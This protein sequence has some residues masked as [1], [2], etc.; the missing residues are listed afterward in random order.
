MNNNKQ[1]AGFASNWPGRHSIPDSRQ[2]SRG[3]ESMYNKILVPLDGSKLAEVV[4]PHLDNFTQG[5][6]S[7]EILLVSVTEKVRM[8]VPKGAFDKNPDPGYATEFVEISGGQ[9]G[10]LI[11]T[12]RFESSEIPLTMGKMAKSAFEYLCQIATKLE[13]QGYK[14]SVNV[15]TGNPAEQI[16]HFAEQEKADV[17]MMGSRG[18]SGFS[19]WDLGNIAEKVLRATQA[20]VVLVKPSVDFKETRTK[21]KGKAL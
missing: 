17:I 7:P 21:R 20:T 13:S 12:T 11:S 4:L 15:L 14:V 8:Q 16:V 1:D 6:K 10:L 5:E 2:K 19:R 18:K 9:S 3:G